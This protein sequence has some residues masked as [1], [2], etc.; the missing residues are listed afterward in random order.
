M[1]N[2]SDFP[3]LKFKKFI[4]VKSDIEYF[5]TMIFIIYP[6]HISHVEAYILEYINKLIL[7]ILTGLTLILFQFKQLV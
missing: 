4:K 3:Q 7:V 6:F 2:T 1:L 5:S